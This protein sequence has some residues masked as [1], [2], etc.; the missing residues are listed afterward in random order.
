LDWLRFVTV[1]VW[2]ALGCP[3]GVVENCN[4]DGDTARALGVGADCTNALKGMLY[5]DAVLEDDGVSGI[6]RVPP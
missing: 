2:G 3:N 5:V 4:T 6:S 1:T